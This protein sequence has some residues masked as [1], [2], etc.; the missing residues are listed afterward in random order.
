MLH[1]EIVSVV[2]TMNS[3]LFFIS[4]T[5][6]VMLADGQKTYFVE[7]IKNEEIIVSGNGDSKLWQK[8]VRLT[9]FEYPWENK[10]STTT[11]FKA[12]HNKEW[13]YCLFEVED[14]DVKVYFVKNDKLEAVNSDRVEIFLKKDDQLSPYYCLEMDANG[15]VLDFE[16]EYHRKFNPGWSWPAGQLIVKAVRTKVGYNVEVAIK[17]ESLVNLGL[18][19]NNKL[20]AGLFRAECLSLVKDQ[21]EMSWISWVHPSSETPDFHIPSAFGTLV[22]K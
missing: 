21:A 12:L 14:P 18:L 20:Q 17:K 15:R 7:N 10:R 6:S 8:A 5:I 13:V 22:L 11:S 4:Y 3:L 1:P 9:D 19:K 16:G 2:K